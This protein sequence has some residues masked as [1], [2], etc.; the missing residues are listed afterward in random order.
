MIQAAHLEMVSSRLGSAAA[1][2]HPE[3]LG[4]KGPEYDFDE[5]TSEHLNKYKNSDK[6]PIN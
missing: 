6:K 2:I 4:A 1:A 3:I 5:S